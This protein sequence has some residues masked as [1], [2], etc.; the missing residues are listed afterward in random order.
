MAIVK[1]K[2]CGHVVTTN[3]TA[4]PGCGSTAFLP[5][6]ECILR[7]NTSDYAQAE[8]SA[9]D[10]SYCETITTNCDHRILTGKSYMV[11]IRCGLSESEF[12]QVPYDAKKVTVWFSKK[13][14]LGEYTG[15][16]RFANIW[17]L[18]SKKLIE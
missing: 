2:E 7:V 6:V 10:Y 14:T 13:C 4:C 15:Q 5:D 16:G 12:I 17:T 18:A 11:K 8:I 1:C 9:L 3:A